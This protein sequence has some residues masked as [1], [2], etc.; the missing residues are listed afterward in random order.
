MEGREGG[1]R[2][3]HA[4]RVSPPAVT[5]ASMLFGYAR[6]DDATTSRSLFPASLHT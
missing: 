2:N 4:Q 3:R 5:Q 1:K 6:L